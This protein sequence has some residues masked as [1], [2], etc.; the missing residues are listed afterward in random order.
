MKH[1]ISLF[2]ELGER[3]R[4][5][6][7]TIEN[8]EFVE[9][10]I[11]DNSWFTEASIKYAIQAVVDNYLQKNRIE[12]WL[13]QYN[14]AEAGKAKNVAVIMAGNIPL[15]GLFDLISV[16][17]SGNRCLYKTSSKDSVLIEYVISI[18]KDID[19]EILVEELDDATHID[20]VIAT[21]GD[22][23]VRL[24]RDKY[25]DIPAIYRGSRLSIAV[26]TGGE[27]IS[28]LKLLADDIFMHAGLGCRN[29]SMIF[30]PQN[31]NL[32]TLTSAFKGYGAVSGKYLNNYVQ[33]RA[34]MKLDNLEFFDGEFFTITREEKPSHIISNIN[35][36]NYTNIKSVEEWIESNENEIQC[37][38]SKIDSMPFKVDIGEA[39]KPALSDYPDRVDTMLFLNNLTETSLCK[40]RRV[41]AEN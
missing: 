41:V 3:L 36:V 30:T 10:A 17:A 31:Y 27:T 25:G 15:V 8:K 22:N 5:A 11:K 7:C 39:Q 40:Q 29:V 37:V 32:T 4:V 33:N 21:G 14:I 19:P 18:L 28:E 20:A 16:V 35:I 12:T 1:M 26:L 9:L 23:T 24:F 13:A 2:S 6:L 38:V 34:I